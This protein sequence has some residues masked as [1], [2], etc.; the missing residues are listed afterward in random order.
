ML[1][2]GIM[3]NI[4]YVRWMEDLRTAFLDKYFPLE[5]MLAENSAPII[6]RTEIDYKRPFT[7][8]EKP[9]GEIWVENFTRS[10]WQLGFKFYTDQRTHCLGKQFGYYF[11]IKRNKPI[12]I[13]ENLIKLYEDEMK[14]DE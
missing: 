11:D 14:A 2:M 5:K 7:I 3:S 9:F 1:C 10:R 6:A 8:N 12:P 4:V 13:P